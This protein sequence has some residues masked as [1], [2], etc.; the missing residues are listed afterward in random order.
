VYSLD[1]LPNA[2][3]RLLPA[4]TAIEQIGPNTWVKR[5]DRAGTV[6]GGNK[7]RKL[8]WLLAAALEG[9]G[10]V[11]AA[12]T[13]GSNHLVATAV[14]GQRVGAHVHAVV[15]AQADAPMVHVNARILH[16]HAEKLWMAETLPAVAAQ[17]A[18]AQVYLRL[19][20]GYP[21]ALLPVGGSNV[22]GCLGWVSG[23]LEI[24]EQVQ[25]GELPAPDRIY[26]A[27]GS[28][29]TAA[30]LLV[31]L[32]LGGLDTEVVAVR[33]APSFLASPWRVRRLAAQTLAHLRR[34]GAPAVALAGLRVVDAFVG[35]GYGHPSQAAEAALGRAQGL[36]LELEST[37]TA[38]A[39]AA[40]LAE[41][42]GRR[43]FL[44]TANTWPL[45]PLLATALDET[46]ASLRGLLRR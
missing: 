41:D 21:P 7:V 31:G 28:G 35:D 18:K 30:G 34:S 23:G 36:G 22:V 44:H 5:E 32:R 33:A 6:Y 25:R 4:P 29:G 39:F 26:V 37:Y 43:L 40:M 10:D 2:R 42:T 14:Y 8:E 19:F 27:L 12:G 17:W 38:K 9:G 20:G 46:P 45:A 3:L 15:A 24:V 13:V 1:G 16:A 11:L